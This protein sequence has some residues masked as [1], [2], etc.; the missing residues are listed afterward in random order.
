MKVLENSITRSEEKDIKYRNELAKYEQKLKKIEKNH[1][2][3]RK[4]RSQSAH[5]L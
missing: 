3:S 1:D 2:E 4:D 5:T